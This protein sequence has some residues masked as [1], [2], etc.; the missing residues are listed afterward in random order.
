MY[1]GQGGDAG[2]IASM[3]TTRSALTPL[4][5]K[6]SCRNGSFVLW[7]RANGY[8][9]A[10]RRTDVRRHPKIRGSA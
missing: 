10:D 4:S 2:K 6:L 7:P 1:D 9:N 8:K 5:I 3:A